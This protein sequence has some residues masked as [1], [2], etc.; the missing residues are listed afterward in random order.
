MKEYSRVKDYTN[1][2]RD[3]S[4]S[5]VVNVDIETLEKIRQRRKL[6]RTQKEQINTLKNDMEE[7]KT[8]M[9]ELITRVN[10]QNS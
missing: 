6:M 10:G 9:K 5:A 7:M 3:E 1:L 2:L 4:S 8:L